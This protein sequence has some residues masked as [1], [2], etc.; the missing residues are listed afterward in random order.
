MRIHGDGSAWHAAAAWAGRVELPTWGLAAAIYGGWLALTWFAAALPV[1][2]VLPAG[3]WLIAWHM[4]L[5]HEVLHGHP[6][7][8]QWL[9]D[10]LGFPPLNLWL[11]YARYRDSHR[12]H[13]RTPHLTDPLDD[14][15]SYYLTPERVAR[16]GWLGR[17]FH[18]LLNTFPGR[19]TLGPFLA[20]G[21]FLTD[22]VRQLRAGDAA[23]WRAWPA[24]LL[25]CVAVLAWV[26]GVCDLSLP[27]YLLVFVLPGVAL[28]LVRSFAEHRADAD[29]AARTAIVEHAP[30]LGLLFL[31]NHLHVVHHARPDLP[32]FAIPRHWR[33]NRAAILA[34]THGPRYAGY[35]TILR[36]YL[37]HPHHPL[38]HPVPARPAR[39]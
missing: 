15:E 9:N 30:L 25:G 3:T 7:R 22:E 14:P 16:L 8:Q 11:P 1:W 28:T 2:A 10:A 26:M 32:W 24:H 6:T 4:S 21:G 12:Q 19:I 17:A 13:H 36:A 39:P 38:A 29:P 34:T 23:S 27:Y 37:L 18:V 5:Q 20:I 33:A 35:G 31:N